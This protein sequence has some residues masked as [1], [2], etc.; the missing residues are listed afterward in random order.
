MV[1]RAIS[2]ILFA[3]F[4]SAAGAF[5]IQHWTTPQ[6]ARVGY[7]H[8]PA[9]PMLDLAVMFDGGSARDGDDHGLAN[10]TAAMLEQG[11]DG[12]SADEIA[13]R[14]DAI[15]AQFATGV[16]KDTANVSLRSLSDSAYLAPALETF[17]AVLTKPDFPGKALRRLINQ[18]LTS[19]KKRAQRPDRLASIAFYRALYGDHPYAHPVNGEADTV[20]TLTAQKLRAFYQRYFTAQNAVITLVGDI[21]RAEAEKIAAQI[22]AALPQGAKAPPLPPV[23]PGKAQ[24]IRIPFDSAQSHVYIGHTGM[25]FNDADYFPLY[26]GNHAL[27]G[28]GF[29]SR[30]LDEVRKK[31]GYV[32]S[33]W[34]YFVPQRENGAFAIN[35]QTQTEQAADAT[36]LVLAMLRDWHEKSIAAEELSLSKDNVRGGFPLRIGDNKSIATWVGRITFF[37]LG[38]DYLDTYAERVGQVTPAMVADAI[39]RRIDPDN[40]IIV[41]VGG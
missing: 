9:L 39:K 37:N 24:N 38:Y 4:A 17:A 36:E 23:A 16:G 12:L 1:C 6:G 13:K 8:S 15:G 27:G 18:E 32:Y 28:S 20:R 22:S 11:A 3:A 2:L 26:L 41:T 21:S 40:L 25:R 5:E 34:S 35:F 10:L 14:L 7:V 33:I 30:L 29:G 31:R 19:I